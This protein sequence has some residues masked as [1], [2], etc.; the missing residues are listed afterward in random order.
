MEGKD[1][2]RLDNEAG[3]Q[4][5]QRVPP[6]ER[7]GRVHSSTVTVTV[8]GDNAQS[9]EATAPF[10]RRQPADY[11]M[12]WFNGTT[13][14]GG[15]HHQKCATCCRMTHVPSGIV[16]TAQTR[17]RVNSQQLAQAALNE[18][19]DGLASQV[20]GKLVNG[21]RKA[22]VGTGERAGVKRRTWRF[23]EDAVVDHITGKRARAVDVMAGRFD[24]LWL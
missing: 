9:A 21:V 1:L 12:E 23:Q 19:L 6:T 16:R 18:E 17:S 24:L 14:A 7:Q 8:L 10:L 15:Q 11:K 22:Q 20:H 3:A 4:R 13:K 5:L 2:R